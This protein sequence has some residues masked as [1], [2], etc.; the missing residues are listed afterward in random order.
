MHSGSV[1]MRGGGVSET[2]GRD[3]LVVL[4]SY[5][6]IKI[7]NEFLQH[8]IWS[9]RTGRH[10]EWTPYVC[11]TWKHSIKF[12]KANSDVHFCTQT[13]GSCGGRNKESKSKIFWRIE[14]KNAREVVDGEK[15][16]KRRGWGETRAGWLYSE[17]TQGGPEPHLQHPPLG[18]SFSAPQLHHIRGCKRQMQRSVF[19]W[20][21]KHEEE[22]QKQ[23]EG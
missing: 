16:K 14:D 3:L 4:I 20:K 21:S 8:E 9:C 2:R 6:H 23:K 1:N 17:E 5:S 19:I 10:S 11:R 12:W 13:N 22:E 7:K 15:L 18:D